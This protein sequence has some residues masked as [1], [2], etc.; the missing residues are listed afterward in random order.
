M[1]G[2]LLFVLFSFALIG[3]FILYE[4]K[5][6]PKRGLVK[7]GLRWVAVERDVNTSK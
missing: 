1:K 3:A 5:N 4:V 6:P 2:F 7:Q